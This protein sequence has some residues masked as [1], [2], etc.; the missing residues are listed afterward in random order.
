MM[1]F[2]RKQQK[3]EDDQ[4]GEVQMPYSFSVVNVQES[5][6]SAGSEEGG[7]L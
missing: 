2:E 6:R 7:L 5:S 1:C 4:V 3:V